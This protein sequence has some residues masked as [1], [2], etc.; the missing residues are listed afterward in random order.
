M[1]KDWYW[2]NV[3]GLVYLLDPN[4]GALYDNINLFP[5]GY[6]YE[7]GTWTFMKQPPSLIS[8]MN[9]SAIKEYMKNPTKPQ[10]DGMDWAAYWQK[11]RA[12]EAA[13][14]F[15]PVMK[16]KKEPKK[17]TKAKAKGPDVT[18]LTKQMNTIHI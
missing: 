9:D 6:Y 16:T 12:K 14:G 13:E 10:K 7:D 11:R 3:N 15:T 4:T 2:K 18:A 1:D 5:S 17:E 8:T